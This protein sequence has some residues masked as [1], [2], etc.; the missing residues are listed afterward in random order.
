MST[1]F[2]AIRLAD[3]D[4]VAHALTPLEAG[5]VAGMDGP[6]GPVSVVIREPIPIYHKFA[7]VDLD[8]GTQVLKGGEVI[9]RTTAAVRAGCHVH[10][11]NLA[12]DRALSAD[13]G[14]A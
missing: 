4:T 5:T 9:G 14:G 7:T 13:E 12:S 2:N 3:G 1:G 11:H 6:D 10:T 8:A